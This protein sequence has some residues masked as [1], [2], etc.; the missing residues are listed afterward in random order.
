ME[1]RGLKRNHEPGFRGRVM[2][3]DLARHYV[4]Y[5]PGELAE[6]DHFLQAELAL[7]IRTFFQLPVQI[8]HSRP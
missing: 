5:E 8:S 7:L 3:G 1:H 2:F 4:K 6:A